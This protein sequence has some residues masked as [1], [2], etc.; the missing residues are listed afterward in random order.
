MK[1]IYSG[2]VVAI[3]LSA[4]A[5]TQMT[6]TS[7]ANALLKKD[8]MKLLSPYAQAKLGCNTIQSVHTSPISV[9]PEGT[10]IEQWQVSGC[11]NQFTVQVDF[12]PDA[13]GGVGINITLQE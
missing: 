3:A 10:V 4:C 13:T 1:N 2:M 5:T 9:S 7:M 6:G 11:N 12:T 8:T